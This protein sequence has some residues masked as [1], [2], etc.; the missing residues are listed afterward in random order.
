MELGPRALEALDIMI[1]KPANSAGANSRA[2]AG[3]QTSHSLQLVARFGLTGLTTTLAYF[4]LTNV[5]V[6]LFK[7]AAVSSSVCAYLVS[8]AISYLL[9]SR[10]TFRVNGD[11]LD[12]VARFL[13]TSLAGLMISW[14]MMGFT[15]LMQLPYWIGAISVCAIVPIMNFF[16]M[17]G[18]VF[19]A[20]QTRDRNVAAGDP[21]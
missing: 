14:C 21:S 11:S 6:L 13:L 8:V 4:L 19:A 7:M 12:Q 16:V 10:F 1:D 9:Q 2:E 5:F 3:L 17:R 20:Q 18:W 15:V